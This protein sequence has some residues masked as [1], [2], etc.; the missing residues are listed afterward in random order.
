MNDIRAIILAGGSGTRL[1]PASRRNHPK[2][3]VALFGEET[4]LDATIS[5]LSPF[6][7]AENIVILTGKSSALGP[8]LEYLRSYAAIIEPE[9]RGTAPAIGVAALHAMLSG[10]DPVLIICPSD[11]AVRDVAVFQQLLANASDI[12]A[13]T[14]NSRIVCFG[15]TPTHAETAYGY[16][17]AH[18]TNVIGEGGHFVEAFREKPDATTASAFLQEGNYFWNAGIL[19][20]RASTILLAIQQ[21]L[22]NLHDVIQSMRE[23][24]KAGASFEAAISAHFAS[25]PTISIDHGV[26]EKL[27]NAQHRSVASA[28]SLQLVLLP[29]D[30]GWSDVGS[31]DAVYDASAKEADETRNVIRGNVIAMNT[32]NCLVHAGKRLVTTLGVSD[33]TI[34]DTPDALLVAQRGQSQH[35]RDLNDILQNR[36]GT[37][38]VEHNTVHHSWGSCSVLEDTPS[39]RISRINMRPSGHL[40]M[41]SDLQRRRVQW[42][43]VSGVVTI[44]SGELCREIHANESVSLNAGEACIIENLGSDVVSV[45]E[46]VIGSL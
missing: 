21:Y 13:D 15:I 20:A 11:H 23:S 32:Q 30:I 45:V 34:I 43:V 5:R 41:T 6:V 44:T 8:A 33:L 38:H 26:L 1:W 46:V 28:D 18:A 37:E 27:T 24:I 29:A 31:W 12:A 7:S 36:D 9:M 3:F 22:P 4:L 14:K 19:V 17:K 42:I 2:Q 35:V 25:A 10:G 40:S 16:I 39:L